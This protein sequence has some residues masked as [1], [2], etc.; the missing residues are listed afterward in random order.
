MTIS[1]RMRHR[2]PVPPGT[3]LRV[4]ARVAGTEA[5][6]ISTTGS[7]ATEEDPSTALVTA[8]GILVAPDPEVARALFPILGNT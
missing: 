2:S 5:R 6:R 7:I 4:L 3:P 8:D 1:L